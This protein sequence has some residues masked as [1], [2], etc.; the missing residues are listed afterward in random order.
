MMNI[1]D[2]FF[3]TLY[4]H[5]IEILCQKVA[6]KKGILFFCKWFY[7][8]ANHGTCIIKFYFTIPNTFQ[9]NFEI[10]FN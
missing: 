10:G 4:D 3:Q 5:T 7:L 9:R 6:N 1:M 2:L 8:Q